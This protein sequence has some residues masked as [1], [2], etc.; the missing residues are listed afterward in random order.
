MQMVTR[1]GANLLRSGHQ[2]GRSIV[3][4]RTVRLAGQLNHTIDLQLH[5]VC[6]SPGEDTPDVKGRVGSGGGGCSN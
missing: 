1:G 6:M 4:T 2:P 3:D 5:N